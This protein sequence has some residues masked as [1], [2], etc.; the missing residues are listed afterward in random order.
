MRLLI[1]LSVVL[2]VSACS[3]TSPRVA[4]H[5]PTKQYCHTKKTVVLTQDGDESVR[6]QTVVECSDDEE[7]R[8]FGMMQGISNHCG[9]VAVWPT[10]NGK[11]TK[12]YAY[13]CQMLDGTYRYVTSPY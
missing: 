8:Y 7:E 4:E 6:S 12:R 5:D 1:L 3:S 11:P 9:K 13:A 2:T 10:I